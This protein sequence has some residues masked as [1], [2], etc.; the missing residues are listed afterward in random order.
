MSNTHSPQ[1]ALAIH[2]VDKNILVSA[3]AGAGKTTVLIDRLMKRIRQDHVSVDEILAM[4]F[5]EAAAGEMKRRLAQKLNEEYKNTGD[6][7]LYDQITKLPGA[8]VKIAY[9]SVRTA[10]CR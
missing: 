7:F 6:P 1:Q 5:T 10:F 4:T 2:T 3:S 8:Y 9:L